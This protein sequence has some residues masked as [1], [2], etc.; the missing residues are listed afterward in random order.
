MAISTIN[1]ATLDGGNGF[2]IDGEGTD[3]F[4]G[5]SVSSAGD[6]NGDGLDD[7]MVGALRSYYFSY[8]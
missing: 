7:V 1:V 2:R 6:I 8:H 5:V 3:F 4:S